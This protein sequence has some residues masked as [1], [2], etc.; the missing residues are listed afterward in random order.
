MITGDYLPVIVSPCAAGSGL[1]ND[2]VENQV[3]MRG[4]VDAC[5]TVR[6]LCDRK[7][8][9]WRYGIGTCS[10]RSRGTSGS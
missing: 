2:V 5:A 1:S 3:Q 8:Y 9:F 10:S 4:I 6:V 7:I